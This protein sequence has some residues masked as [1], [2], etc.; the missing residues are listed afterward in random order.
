MGDYMD[1][2]ELEVYLDAIDR[3]DPL[4]GPRQPRIDEP[5]FDQLRDERG[6]RTPGCYRTRPIV[7]P[8]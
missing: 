1:E 3:I 4:L 7:T 2:D 5:I 6:H 8:E